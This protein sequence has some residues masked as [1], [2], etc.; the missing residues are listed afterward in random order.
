M[1]TYQYICTLFTRRTLREERTSKISIIQFITSPWYVLQHRK[2]RR[3]DENEQTAEEDATKNGLNDIHVHRRV[4][5]KTLEYTS[6][7]SSMP[8]TRDTY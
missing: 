8:T 7:P 3:S 2:T 4:K 6:W 5:R 1:A